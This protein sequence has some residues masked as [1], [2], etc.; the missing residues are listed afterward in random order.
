[1]TREEALESIINPKGYPFGD[2]PDMALHNIGLYIDKI[3]DGFESRS[4]SECK[5][6]SEFKRESI[7]YCTADMIKTASGKN[8]ATFNNYS[9]YH[10]SCDKFER[11]SDN[12]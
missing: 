2:F 11:K 3:Y 9:A 6:H 8:N 5:Y 12:E 10:L 1:M 7:W 4:C